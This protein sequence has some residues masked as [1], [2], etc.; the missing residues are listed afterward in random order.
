[1]T[2]TGSCYSTASY[3][4]RNL[5][6]LDQH[7]DLT[8]GD[9]SGQDLT[10]ATVLDADERRFVG[11]ESHECGWGTSRPLRRSCGSGDPHERQPCWGSGCRGDFI[12]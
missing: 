2:L 6:A 11:N 1:M 12:R 10:G 5:R 9:F 7:H 4:Q 3:Q 8:G